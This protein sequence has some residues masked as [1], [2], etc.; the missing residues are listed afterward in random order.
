MANLKLNVTGQLQ[1]L[2][3]LSGNTYKFII[4]YYSTT[5]VLLTNPE[6]IQNAEYDATLTTNTFNL[7]FPIGDGTYTINSVK[8]RVYNSTVTE[9]CF[10]EFI[11]NIVVNCGGEE[12]ICSPAVQLLGTPSQSCIDQDTV[13]ING[14]ALS[15][16][17]GNDSYQWA[18]VKVSEFISVEALTF[19]TTKIWQVDHLDS[20]RIYVKD[21]SLI[22]D[23]T[24]YD[25]LVVITGNC[26][27]DPDPGNGELEITLYY[28]E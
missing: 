6:L 4:R 17:G 2:I 8:I 28:N 13:E 10:D 16:V 9:N 22:D 12:E 11:T 14:T 7:N 27:E 15:A 5:D 20:Y 26:T 23:S 3:P 19:S 24:C 21:T 18:I 25:Y 1:N